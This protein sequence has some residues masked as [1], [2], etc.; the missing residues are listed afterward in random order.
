[1]SLIII[2]GGAAGMMAALGYKD[3]SPEKDVLLL[4]AND[5]LGKK[6]YAT[7]NGRCN[8]TNVNMDL[9][10]FHSM[11]PYFYQGALKRF[12]KDETVAYWQRLGIMPWIEESTGKLFPYARQAEAVVK[13]LEYALV[14][15]GV[16]VKLKEPATAIRR[17]KKAW[18]VTTPRGSYQSETVIL[19]TGGKALPASGSDGNGYALAQQLGH[20]LTP[21][22]PTLVHLQVENAFA[23]WTLGVKLAAWLSLVIDRQL[24]ARYEGD[25]NWTKDGLSGPPVLDVSRE[26]IVA[27]ET[28]HQVSLRIDFMGRPTNEVVVLLR[29]RQRQWPHRPAELLLNGLLPPKLIRPVLE[30][31][32]LETTTP[33]GG[34]PRKA[35]Q[36]LARVLTGWEFPVTG[37]RDF[38]FAQGTMGG[39]KTTDFDPKTLMSRKAPGFYAVGEVLDVD[40]DCGGYNLQWAWSSGYVAGRHAAGLKEER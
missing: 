17:R 2:G 34:I 7:G 27:L 13:A 37:Y 16:E 36:Q 21:I 30:T 33:I 29:E 11:E 32:K 35:L 1:M 28:G 31:A 14:D 38:T 8:Y 40:G 22:Y 18:E 24:V 25:V 20:E 12:T 15:R 19:A 26:A 6:L 5:R 10:H 4:E 3:T 9:V 23:R 39:L